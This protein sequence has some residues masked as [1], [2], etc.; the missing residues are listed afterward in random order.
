MSVPEI[1]GFRWHGID[2]R[3]CSRGGFDTA[4]ASPG[5]LAEYLYRMG[6]RWAVI[7]DPQTAAELGGVQAKDTEKPR[8]WWGESA[9]PSEGGHIF[10]RDWEPADW[11]KCQ[12]PAVVTRRNIEPLGTDGIWPGDRR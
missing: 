3:G 10:G 5:D 6:Y 4:A 7:E 11:A 9:S 1:A 8:S 2:E 12:R